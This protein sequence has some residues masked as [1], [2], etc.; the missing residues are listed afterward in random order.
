MNISKLASTVIMATSISTILLFAFVLCFY[1][2]D[3]NSIDKAF[4]ITASFFGG[5][6]TLIAAYIAT[7]LFND[8]K[9]QHNKNIDSQ[10]CMKIYDFID[11]A[12]IELFVISNYLRDYLSISDEKKLDYVDQLKTHGQRLLNLKD[13]S[14]IKLSNVGYFINKEEYELKYLT[15]IK[16]IDEHLQKY[17]DLYEQYILG[18]YDHGNIEKLQNMLDDLMLDTR[19]RLR[20]V[21]IELSKYYKA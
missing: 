17:Q 21:I 19:A 6:A 15:Q 14:L 10:F 13:S 12:N 8:W 9:E 1:N 4:S 7:Q 16:I 2:G 3:E 11:F 18:N 20:G 5:I